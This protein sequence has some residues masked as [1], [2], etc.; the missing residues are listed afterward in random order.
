MTNKGSLGFDDMIRF[1]LNALYDMTYNAVRAKQRD[2]KLMGLDA[3]D[4]NRA[5]VSMYAVKS[6]PDAMLG[7]SALKDFTNRVYQ[8]MDECQKRGEDMNF[9]AASCIVNRAYD[10]LANDASKAT[11]LLPAGLSHMYDELLR[12]VYESKNWLN[13]QQK[14][15]AR[16]NIMAIYNRLRLE[17][18]KSLFKR[19]AMRI[20]MLFDNQIIYKGH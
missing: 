8:Y 17:T 14:E 10:I 6:N 7:K 9:D 2:G 15:T 1:S 16:K 4:A 19:E 11:I 13:L 3:T 5:L 20:K 18:E 12:A